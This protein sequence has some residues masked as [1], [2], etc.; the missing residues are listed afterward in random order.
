MQRIATEAGSAGSH[1]SNRLPPTILLSAYACEPGAGSEAA[2]GWGW[3]RQLAGTHQVHVITRE[4]NREK[5]EAELSVRP[6]LNVRF[7]YF[8]LPSWVLK[9]KRGGVGVYV[10]YILWQFFAYRHIARKRHGRI[11][12]DIVHHVTF[13]SVRLPSFMALLGRPFV[14]GPVGGGE[15]SPVALWWP[16]G[17]GA[18]IRETARYVSL[19]WI[20][21]SPLMRL[22]LSGA[23]TLFVTTPQ[24]G[25]VLPKEFRS[26]AQVMLAIAMSEDETVKPEV[27]RRKT[28]GVFRIVYAGRLLYWKGVEY[29]LHG[30]ARFA[31]EFP[32]SE[33]TIVGSGPELVRWQKIASGLSI[34]SRVK[35]MS[36]MRHEDLLDFLPQFDAFLFPSLHDSGGMVVM[37]ALGAGLPVICLDVGG[38]GDLVTESCGFKLPASRPQDV[39]DGICQSLLKLAR[40]PDLREAMGKCGRKRIEQH[41]TWASKSIEMQEIYDELLRNRATSNACMDETI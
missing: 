13:A 22:T 27:D 33:M 9:L 2:V 1:A 28:P 6:F 10:Y 20:R 12:F 15:Y 29:G 17:W 5:I 23:S 7:C 18:R 4:S 21:F 39:V 25:D 37:E 34:A 31:A 38:P 41:Y 19:R 32:D 36:A 24:T 14:F 3:V 26:K 8:D 35:W 16:L 30:F 40:D 11:S